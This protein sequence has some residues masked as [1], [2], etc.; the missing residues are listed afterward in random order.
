[1]SSL[2]SLSGLSSRLSVSGLATGL[3]TEK[4]IEALLTIQTKQLQSLEAK[5]AA[6]VQKQTAFKGVESKLLGLQTALGSL[7]KSQNGIFDVRKVTSSAESL[8]TASATSTAVPGSYT[9]RVN[10]LARA[11]QIA[12]QGFDDANST[13]TQGTIQIGIGSTTKTITIDATNNTVTGLANAINSSGAGV[14]A[15][16]IRDGRNQP[17]RLVLSSTKTGTQNAITVVNNLAADSGNA[18]KPELSSTYIGAAVKDP[19]FT[20]TSTPASNSGTGAY[21]GTTN[22]RY[23]FTVVQ[24]GTVGLSLDIQIAYTDSTGANTG[25]ITLGLGDID[26]FKTVAQGVQVKFS[27][28][29]LVAGEKFTLDT[30]VPTVQQAADASLTLGSGSGALTITSPTNQVEG[31]VPGVTLNLVGAD[32]TK[33]VTVTVASDTEKARQAILDLIDSF[34]GVM[35]FIDNLV[36]YD[37][38]T[39]KAGV[40][41]GN[42]SVI[43]IQDQ[44]RDIMTQTVA[45]LPSLM[46][47][48]G[49]LGVTIT[50]KGRL[51][52]NTT[53]LDDAL[54]GR[55]T[56][57]TLDDVRRLFTLAGKSTNS[58]I[59]FVTGSAKTKAAA[60]PY[61]VDVTQAATQAKMTATTP[62]AAST[63]ISASNNTFT[64]TV[65]G[66]LSGTLTIANG[67][68]T[69]AQLAQAVQTSINSNSDLLGRQVAVTLDADRLVITSNTYG[70]SS[71]VRIGTGNALATLG[72]VGSEN[73]TGQNVAGSFIVNGQSES[74]TGNGQFL[75]GN[76]SNANTADL[77]VRVTLTSSQV[78]AG[79][80]ADL[81]ITRGV[82]SKLDQALA[83]MM[84]PVTGRLKTINDGFED[85]IED[86]QETMD[87]QKASFEARRQ[88]LLLQFIALESTVS[89]LKSTGDFLATQ[90][91]VLRPATRK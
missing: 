72:F 15:S 11:H 71:E 82:A 13:I 90:L 19:A 34:N 42:R 9:F 61:Q 47:R 79:V 84:D 88:A 60:N 8:V 39:Q 40:L 30:Y 81:T 52:V 68:Y 56:G 75:V 46:N 58:G 28:G 43:G 12:S 86:I 83:A 87:R 31:I 29:T 21:T 45:G 65:D 64:I 24:G 70:S 59:Q 50:D 25:T 18:R 16:V 54:A 36:S 74:A 76:T 5:Q 26:V 44:V 3:D 48:L 14:T 27:S 69:R 77:Q 20:G 22:N 66:K 53:K 35:E 17:Y 38:E 67:T 33:D 23:T 63:V 62:L 91:T 89:K 51:V 55:V 7:A 73:G 37:K 41:L 1:M 2:S 4:I 32:S 6:V 10:N 49:A 57:V 78:Q 85:N 80:D